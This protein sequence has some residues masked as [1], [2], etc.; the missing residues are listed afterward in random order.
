MWNHA[1]VAW[2]DPVISDRLCVIRLPSMHCVRR[3]SFHLR[4]GK[5]RRRGG[6]GC[7][8]ILLASDAVLLLCLIFSLVMVMIDRLGGLWQPQSY[9]TGYG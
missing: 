6:A 2:V 8:E 5:T 3:I 7:R 1:E 4:S 9:A